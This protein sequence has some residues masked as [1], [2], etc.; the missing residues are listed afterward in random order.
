SLPVIMCTTH[1]SLAKIQ[2]ALMAGANEYIMKP[3]DAEIIGN[4][5]AAIGIAA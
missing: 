2:E 1:N 3:F 4:K 5:L